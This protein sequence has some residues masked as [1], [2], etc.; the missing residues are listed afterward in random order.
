M[1]TK[2]S[3]LI[4]SPLGLI[5]L[6]IGQLLPQID[7]SIV[8]VALN[9][10][11]QD[12]HASE[13]DLVL[14]ISLYSLSFATLIATGARLGD[15]YGRKKFFLIGTVGFCISSAI[16]GLAINMYLMLFGRVLQGGFAA[17]LLPQILTTIHTTL[18]GERHR[19]AV[20]IYTSIAGLSVAIGQILGGWLISSNFWNLGWRVAFFINIPLCLI[21]LLLGYKVIP[22]T[23]NYKVQLIDFGGIFWI[24]I[25]LLLLLIPVT[26][27]H[28]WF[29]LWGL[30]PCVLPAIQCLWKFEKKQEKV[31]KSPI[32]PPS[33]FN[34]PLVIRGFISEMLVTFVY[35]GYLFVTALYLQKALQFTPIQSGNTFITLG[36]MFFIG[37]LMSKSL[38]AWLNDSK[39]YAIGLIITAIGFIGT[40]LVFHI[41]A[42]H[43]KYYQLWLSTGLVGFGNAMMLTSAFRITL[44]CVKENYASE[45]SS[46]LTTVQQGCFAIGTA[47]AGAIYAAILNHGYL[48]AISTSITV[49]TLLLISIGGYNCVKT[50]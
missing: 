10:I 34:I 42:D 37:S 5:T 13:I 41:Y 1:N 7:F 43:L 50:K 4:L 16:C 23:R 19:R 14:M 39:T 28:E 15:R 26:L 29:Y 48:N 32:L 25:C 40:I 12:L 11:G 17:L 3:K 18:K 49:L 27:G 47:F 44:S 35:P 21:I 38:S 2:T 9:V 36:I 46:A 24:I 30:L 33:L 22:E 8:N 45:A 31:G 6:V 20:G